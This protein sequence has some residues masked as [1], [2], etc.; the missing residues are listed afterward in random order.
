LTEAIRLNPNDVNAISGYALLLASCPRENLRDGKKAVELAKKACDLSQGKNPRPFIVLA[1]AHA[2][3]GD[4]PEAIKWV[5]KAIAMNPA[6]RDAFR[7][8][9]MLRL[10][11][12]GK[13]YRDE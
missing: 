3:C 4:F 13:P 1:A 10:F 12:Q 8:Q 7:A 2:E 5:K 9:A 11:E 6:I